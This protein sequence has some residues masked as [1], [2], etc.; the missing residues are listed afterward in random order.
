MKKGRV[1]VTFIGA[2]QRQQLGAAKKLAYVHINAHTHR[3][4]Y[5]YI[6]IYIYMTIHVY[7][8]H[9]RIPL[10]N[11]CPLNFFS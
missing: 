11:P 9:D 7:K 2:S 8:P 3:N 1:L 10:L 5:I 6:Y 4:M